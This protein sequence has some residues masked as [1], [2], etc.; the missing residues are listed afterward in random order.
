[1]VKFAEIASGSVV[2]LGRF[3]GERRE[4]SFKTGMVV[5]KLTVKLGNNVYTAIVVQTGAREKLEVQLHNIQ[6]ILA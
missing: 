2:Q 6:A 1:M 4:H 3:N 5:E